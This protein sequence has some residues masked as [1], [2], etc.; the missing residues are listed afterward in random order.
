MLLKAI[1]PVP[2]LVVAAPVDKL[3]VVVTHTCPHRLR[4][5]GTANRLKW[6]HAQLDEVTHH[7]IV[8]LH[9]HPDVS[10]K[11]RLVITAQTCSARC[12]VRFVP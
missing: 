12:G 1:H 5:T 4:A 6:Y 2:A 9:L 7:L 10:G 11:R 3:L 8:R